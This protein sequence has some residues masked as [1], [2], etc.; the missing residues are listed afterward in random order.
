M[1]I[2]F[3]RFCLDFELKIIIETVMENGLSTIVCL[4]SL[5]RFIFAN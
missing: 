5:F 4:A 2:S 3:I 1:L